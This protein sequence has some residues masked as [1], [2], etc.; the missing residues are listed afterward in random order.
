MTSIFFCFSQ[1][2]EK[3]QREN[4]PIDVELTQGLFPKTESHINTLENTSQDHCI[5]QRHQRMIERWQNIC[6]DVKIQHQVS[7]LGKNFDQFMEHSMIKKLILIEKDNSVSVV[8]N[9][10]MKL[11]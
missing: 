11:V 4:F 9:L 5:W 10:S 8:A 7:N 6:D 1:L 2:P 3:S